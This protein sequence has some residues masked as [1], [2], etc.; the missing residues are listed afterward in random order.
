VPVVL[1][2]PQFPNQV[3]ASPTTKAFS[4]QLNF[5]EMVG[6][7]T[8][9]NSN[10]DTIQAGRIINN[11]YR[12]VIDRRSWYGL[13]VRGIASV[14]NVL[15]TGTAT[16]TNGSAAVT[17]NGTSWTPAL[18]GLQFRP[19][20]T[21]PYQTII[22]VDSTTSLT[23]DTPYQGFSGTGGY[24]IVEAYLTFG[25]NI[26]RF[27]WAVNQ[28]W[29]W[30]MEVNVPI[31][32]VNARDVWRQQLGWATVFA[33]RP[34]TTDGQFQVECWPTPYAA[35]QFPFEAWTEPP[36]L[37]EDEDAPVAWIRSDVLVTGGIAD[38]L[39][40]RPKANTYYSEQTAVAV[41][42]EKR[43]QFEKY[44]LEM[45]NADEGL[46]QQAVTWNYGEEDDGVG[47]GTGSTWSQMHD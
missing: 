4:V 29:G 42:G 21:S 25:A 32:T 19:S 38:A 8:Q 47:T 18:L 24:Q 30:P 5:R 9:W 40:F 37:T 23:L 17:G 7:L 14:P 28:L 1:S 3:G 33:T 36:V 22:R 6:E 12:Q 16:V 11:R 13:K 46:Q 31:Q 20:M 35:Q 39:L 26:K 43:T 41:A 2:N 34:P 45:E 15:Q 44:L 27:D 10:L